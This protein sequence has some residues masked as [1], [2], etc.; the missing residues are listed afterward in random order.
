MCYV[1]ENISCQTENH[2]TY[3]WVADRWDFVFSE[4]VDCG[5]VWQRSDCMSRLDNN[6]LTL[7]RGA[8]SEHSEL[9]RE[10]SAFTEPLSTIHY[11]VGALICSNPLP[12]PKPDLGQAAQ[13]ALR[14]IK[15]HHP[16]NSPER[17]LPHKN[18][19]TLLS[20]FYVM[21]LPPV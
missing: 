21:D 19:S 13:P 5:G 16:L 9:R 15:T 17:K 18:I 6:S 8:G 1:V 14:V 2:R 12:D 11:V 10:V 4:A 7:V 20:L 3:D